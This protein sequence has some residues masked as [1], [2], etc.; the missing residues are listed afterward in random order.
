MKQPQAFERIHG[1]GNYVLLVINPK[2]KFPQIVPKPRKEE[3]KKKK[4]KGICE[5]HVLMAT[6]EDEWNEDCNLVPCFK[7]LGFGV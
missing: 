6:K 7:L 2:E 3:G 1:N 4:K 5:P